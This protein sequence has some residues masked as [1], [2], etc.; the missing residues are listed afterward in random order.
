VAEGVEDQSDWD[1]L[2]LRGCNLAQGY[3]IAPPM[4][5]EDLPAW[6]AAW[7]LRRISLCASDEAKKL[8]PAMFDNAQTRAAHTE[9]LGA[10]DA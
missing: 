8:L 4:P 9:I 2:R 10:C 6:L 5:A 3:F 7:E 1:F